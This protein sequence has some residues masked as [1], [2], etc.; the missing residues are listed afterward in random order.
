M[1]RH[2]SRRQLGGLPHL[3]FSQPLPPRLPVCLP[4]LLAPKDVSPVNGASS[5]RPL[6][7]MTPLCS[8]RCRY[9][10]CWYVYAPAVGTTS[11]DIV[12]HF[13]TQPIAS[14]GSVISINTGFLKVTAAPPTGTCIGA[15]LPPR[16]GFRRN[17]R[18][19]TSPIHIGKI[20]KP[21]PY[22]LALCQ[23]SVT[24]PLMSPEST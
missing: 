17:H 22:W 16:T 11:G 23:N 10:S 12:M 7:M 13:S 2:P 6:P 18:D 9:T 8:L 20:K 4:R 1:H 24:Q 5:P 19:L 3:F 21:L 14:F 15:A